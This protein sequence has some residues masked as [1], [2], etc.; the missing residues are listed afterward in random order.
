MHPLQGSVKL[1]KTLCSDIR[2]S[3]VSIVVGA[4]IVSAGSLLYLYKTVR[5]ATIAI[6]TTPT[7]LWVAILLV[8]LGCLYTYIKFRQIRLS[9]STSPDSTSPDIATLG[10]TPYFFTI[11]DYKWAV[12]IYPN[13]NFSVD[14][15]P[16][17]A[18]HDLRFILKGLDKVCPA[19]GCTNTISASDEYKVFNTAKSYI[20]KDI[21]NGNY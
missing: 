6:L 9:Y 7:P 15:F 5:D 4:A 3:I 8:L 17:C 21:R 16:F 18:K 11:G 12:K 13:G 20:E 14:V 2:Q 19:D 1:L 10:Y